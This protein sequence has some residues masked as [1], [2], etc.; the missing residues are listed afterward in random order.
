[1]LACLAA[2]LLCAQGA[3]N[4][5]D[6]QFADRL[7][8]AADDAGRS[9]LLAAENASFDPSNVLAVLRKRGAAAFQAYDYR[10]SRLSWQTA[11]SV[12]QFMRSDREVAACDDSLAHILYREAKYPEAIALATQGLKS[13]ENAADPR[14]E[15]H[16]WRTIANSHFNMGEFRESQVANEKVLKL[17]EELDDQE[18]VAATLGS[19]GGDHREQDDTKVAIDYFR[20]SW[21]LAKSIHHGETVNFALMGLVRIYAAQRD[22]DLALSYLRQVAPVSGTSLGDERWRS[23]VLAQYASIYNKMKR[24]AD[25]LKSADEGFAITQ[26]THDD[27]LAAWFL[28]VRGED[29]EGL[30]HTRETIQAYEKASEMFERIGAADQQSAALEHIAQ[31]YLDLGEMEPALR[32]A[33]KAVKLS[34]KT[35]SPDLISTALLTE[36]RVYRRVGRAKEAESAFLEAI[37]LQESWRAKLAG[38]STEGQ[39]FF[40]N[41]MGP[42]RE[43]MEMRV[44]AGDIP[45]AIAAAERARARHLLDMVTQARPDVRHAMSPEERQRET[46]LDRIA[47]QRLVKADAS[48]QSKAAFDQAAADLKSFRAD[49]YLRHPDLGARR[50]ESRP[51]SRDEIGS[52]IPDARTVLVEYVVSESMD[53]YVFT[54][55]RTSSGQLEFSAHLLRYR[56]PELE[57]RVEQFRS[58]LATRDLSYRR[59]ARSLYQDLLGPVENQLAHRAVVAILPDGPL[60]NLPFHTLIGHDGKYL[61]EHAAVFYAPS[62]TSMR[63]QSA[64]PRSPKSPGKTLL[65]MAGGDL[66]FAQQEVRGLREI[67]GPASSAT[68][69]GAD[70]TESRWKQDAPNYAILHL[71]THSILNASNPLFSYLMLKGTNGQ[72]GMLQAREILDLDVRAELAVLSACETARGEVLE[73]EGVFGMS[74]AMMMAGVR[75]V[76]VSQWKVDSASTTKFMLAFHRELASH[77]AKNGELRDKAE[78]LRRASLE[79]WK[80][81]EYQHPFYWAGFQMLGDGY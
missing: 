55:A 68:Y 9:A 8:S 12:A 58:A 71:A 67:Y 17:Y 79:L 15:A 16:L 19:L 27:R 77:L 21:D 42:Y 1:M 66:P 4:T 56:A 31:E 46:E 81:P 72:D 7:E 20:R 13:A 80:T 70:A 25:S 39:H 59:L 65:A 26:K 73:G 74:W 48:P 57:R 30:G 49:L 75:S 36:G 61:V 28:E 51:L 44:E 62:L 35:A 32:D 45:A 6:E 47:T 29:L 76:V 34:R 2:S 40:E 24:Y 23:S 5:T 41:R 14:M 63:E 10:A 69:T 60:W 43:L 38:G 64:R 52:L 11:L 78:S 37:D 33:E 50:G 18:Q 54:I 22:F 3:Q 53:A